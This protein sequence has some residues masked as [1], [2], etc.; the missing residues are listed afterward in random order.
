MKTVKT[1]H[2]G[3][4]RTVNAY[5]RQD[6]LKLNW[7]IDLAKYR[8]HEDWLIQGKPDDGS[9]CVGKGINV[10]YLGPRK[11]F[12]VPAKI[13]RCDWVQ[14]NMAAQ[15]TVKGALAFL[16]KHGVECSYDDGAMD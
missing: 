8:W 12:A 15:K 10:W 2:A 11:R 9:C 14:G 16:K 6:L 4:K 3:S 13:I 5:Q 1:F 7:I